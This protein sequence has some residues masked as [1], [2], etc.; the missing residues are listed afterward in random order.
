MPKKS[1]NSSL[2]QLSVSA[3]TNGPSSV[4]GASSGLS[5]AAVDGRASADGAAGPPAKRP[6]A[7]ADSPSPAS[8]PHSAKSPAQLEVGLV[9]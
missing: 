3:A 6:R 2:Q 8:T 4:S 5:V 7:A 1:S 9:G